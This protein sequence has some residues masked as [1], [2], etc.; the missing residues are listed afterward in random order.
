MSGDARGG[1][2]LELSELESFKSETAIVIYNFLHGGNTIIL[3]KEA[4]RFLS[5]AKKAEEEEAIEG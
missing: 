5:A 1:N 3:L 4:R 2:L